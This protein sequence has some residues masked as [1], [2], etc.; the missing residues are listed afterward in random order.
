MHGK[1]AL[2]RTGAAVVEGGGDG[3]G[4][5]ETLKQRRRMRRQWGQHGD[6]WASSIFGRT[7]ATQGEMKIKEGLGTR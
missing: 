5:Q 1:R 6:D 4:W 7:A 2:G 3:S